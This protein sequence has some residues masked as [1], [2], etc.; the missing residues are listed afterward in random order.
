MFAFGRKDVPGGGGGVPRRDAGRHLVRR[1]RGVLPE[2]HPARQVRAPGDAVPRCPTTIICGTKDK[3]TSIGHSRKMA[4]RLPDATL[5][6]CEGAGHMVIFESRDQVN[7]ALEELVESADRHDRDP[8]RR[9]LARGRRARRHPR[10]V[11]QPAAARPAGD[12][13]RRDRRVDARGAR[14]PRRPARRA[15]RHSRSVRCCSS[16]VGGCS[17]CAGS[18][19]S[20]RCAGSASPRRWRRE[21][22]EIAAAREFG[23]LE[24]EARVELPTTIEF[25][26]NLG[27][28]ESE[29]NGNRLNMLRMLPITA[30]PARPPRTP[31]RSASGWPRCCAPATW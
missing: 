5:V 21:A 27:Y 20:T 8:D 18:A 3:L 10:G 7:E 25:W 12:R 11:R 16:R 15:R 31:V 6:E 30:R 22:E 13:A 1:A 19:C 4:E 2:L 23:G 28:V 29:R 9:R 17:G 14:R 26:R 24:I